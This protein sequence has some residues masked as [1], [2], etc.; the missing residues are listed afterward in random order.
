MAT[1]FS[2]THV[3]NKYEIGSVT[4]VAF[5]YIHGTYGSAL[6]VSSRGATVMCGPFIGLVGWFAAGK[7]RNSIRPTKEEQTK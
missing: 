5:I 3:A 2:A 4:G 6:G 7:F 1:L